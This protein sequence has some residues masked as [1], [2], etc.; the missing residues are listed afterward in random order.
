MATF[1]L[2][3]LIGNEWLWTGYTWCAEYEARVM[4]AAAEREEG[5]GGRGCEGPPKG[6]EEQW[7]R[8]LLSEESGKAGK[9]S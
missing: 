5:G 2:G 6:E 3:G 4:A 1:H 9:A 8:A 7:L